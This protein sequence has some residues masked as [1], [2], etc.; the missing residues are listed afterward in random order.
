LAALLFALTGGGIVGASPPGNDPSCNASTDG[1]C[2]G[3]KGRGDARVCEN[4][5]ANDGTE[6]AVDVL[7]PGEESDCNSST[8]T[9]ST[10]VASTTTTTTIVDDNGDGLD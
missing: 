10:T 4:A 6:L 3:D 2:A 9:T 5:P 1:T 7:Q 8:S